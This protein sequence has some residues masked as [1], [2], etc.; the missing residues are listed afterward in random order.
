MVR[1][2]A[3]RERERRRRFS[4]ASWKHRSGCQCLP[5]HRLMGGSVRRG[6]LPGRRGREGGRRAGGL[7]TGCRGGESRVEE[8]EDVDGR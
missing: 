5:C 8:K 4:A 1:G 6:A 2:E 3:E 7:D